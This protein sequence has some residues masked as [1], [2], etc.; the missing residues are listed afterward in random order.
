[1]PQIENIIFR[2][3]KSFR[4]KDYKMALKRIYVLIGRNNC[5]KSS[6]IDVI[7]AMTDYLLFQN[8]QVDILCDVHLDKEET[9][10][11]KEQSGYLTISTY[12]PNL[13]SLSLRV[14]DSNKETLNFVP[15]KETVQIINQGA[16][17][18]SDPNDSVSILVFNVNH[19][20][21]RIKCLRLNAERDIVPEEAGSSLEMSVNGTGA[22]NLIVTVQSC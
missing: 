7:E 4:N 21:K 11:K 1:M 13:T 10:D 14:D 16:H 8:R 5:G 12:Y 9:L 2:N 18:L 15:T 19:Y 3:Y 17:N 20:C 6:C 22:T